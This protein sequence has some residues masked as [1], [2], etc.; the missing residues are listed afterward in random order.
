MSMPASRSELRQLVHQYI[1]F[2]EAENASPHTI[3][4]YQT[5]LEDWVAFLTPPGGQPPRV[6]EIDRLLMREWMADLYAQ[7]LQA[8]SVRRK[9]ACVRSFFSWLERN[10]FVTVNVARQVRTP[11]M[12][13]LLPHVP[14]AETTN[15]LIDSVPAA[16]AETRRLH[17]ARDLAILELLYGCG[18][19][20][21]E[22]SGLDVGDVDA[23][24]CFL[25]VRGKGRKERRVP[26]GSRAAEALSAYMEQRRPREGETAVFLNHRGCRLTDRGARGIVHFYADQ[27]LHDSSIHPHSFRHAYAT[28]MLASGADLRA[29]QDL[30]G[31]AQLA[32]TQRYT[33]VDLTDLMRVYDKCHPK[34]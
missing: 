3:R 32:T 7:Q 11:R 2:L 18:L 1:S 17:P 23:A 21:S 12:P 13:S 14:S 5:D 15:A 10:G 30:L 27:V 28:H 22:L 19:R 8:A 33:R 25:L 29:I 6:R 9:L 20:I 26:Y 4:S 34:A 16:A 31:H 24:S